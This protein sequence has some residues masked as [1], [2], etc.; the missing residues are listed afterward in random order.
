M[1]ASNI[2]LPGIAFSS[3]L[4]RTRESQ[5]CKPSQDQGRPAAQGCLVMWFEM[6]IPAHTFYMFACRLSYSFS[7]LFRPLQMLCFFCIIPISAC[8]RPEQPKRFSVLREIVPSNRCFV[9]VFPVRQMIGMQI[10][11]R[12]LITVRYTFSVWFYTARRR[13]TYSDD[14]DYPRRQQIHTRTHNTVY[15]ASKKIQIRLSHSVIMIT[16]ARTQWKT[17]DRLGGKIR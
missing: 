17:G 11:P 4:Q 5:M 14:Y 13:T 1:A 10:L 16:Y 12:K 15:E 7:Y 9:V 6:R 3:P 2:A 8:S